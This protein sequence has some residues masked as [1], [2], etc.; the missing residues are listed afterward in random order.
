[1]VDI[2][3]YLVKW[4]LSWYSFYC[5]KQSTFQW[6]Y[7]HFFIENDSWT[8]CSSKV[9]HSHYEIISTTNSF[10][11][12]NSYKIKRERIYTHIRNAS[13]IDVKVQ[14]RYETKHETRSVHVPSV[15][16]WMALHSVLCATRSCS[17]YTHTHL[18]L[19]T[20]HCNV[21][22]WKSK[23]VLETSIIS[24]NIR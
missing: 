9:F 5:N 16:W 4:L 21:C 11:Y 7:I 23:F 14:H 19:W 8:A 17:S 3:W 10:F 15:F 13:I 18:P 1:M 12:E 6:M 2:V 22:V 24:C 20:Y